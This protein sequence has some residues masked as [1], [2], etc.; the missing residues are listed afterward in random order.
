ML[1]I[2]FLYLLS[3]NIVFLCIELPKGSSVNA[4]AKALLRDQHDTERAVAVSIATV[5]VEVEDARVRAIAA[6]AA[7]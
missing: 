6:V 7:T 1:V 3:F 5:A 4:K 2:Y